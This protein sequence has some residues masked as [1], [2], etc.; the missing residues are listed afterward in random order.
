MNIHKAMEAIRPTLD[1]YTIL[2]LIG[3]AQG[4]FL[5]YFFFINRRSN[6][7]NIILGCLILV[8]TLSLIEIFLNYTGLIISVIPLYN[9]SEPL[10]FLLGPLFY[11]YVRIYAGRKLPQPIWIHFL[12]FVLYLLYMTIEFS[13]PATQ[14]YN[15]YLDI[16]HPEVPLLALS[17]YRDH[18]PLNIKPAVTGIIILLHL[19]GYFILSLAV[20]RAQI[21]EKFQAVFRKKGT[22]QYRWLVQFLFIVIIGIL[23]FPVSKFSFKVAVG[24]NLMGVYITFFIY[25]IGYSI[26]RRSPFFRERTEKKYH[27]STLSEKW[28][29]Q[30]MDQL[31][32]VMA[33]EKP[34]IKNSFSRSDLADRLSISDHQLSQV[35][36]ERTDTNFFGMLNQ[37]RT[38]EAKKMLDD[39]DNDHL[40]IE[41]IAYDVGY[42]SKSAFYAAF[43]KEF[44]CTPHAYRKSK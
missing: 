33:E 36:N 18:D 28:M 44:N 25:L 2:L 40:K 4:I 17:S 20:L 8:L 13:L 10:Q 39:P 29:D 32:T 34:F 6:P 3:L 30:K 16:Y 27:T 22:E 11:F 5:T 37:Y 12:P 7:T 23:L 24:E 42:N 41:Q 21:S 31:K 1:L 9:F 26:I 19:A 15:S 35:I 38:L 14:K 43:K